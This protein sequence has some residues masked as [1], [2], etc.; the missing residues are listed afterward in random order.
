MSVPG[1]RPRLGSAY[2][3][4][5][6][7]RDDLHVALKQHMTSVRLG[8]DQINLDAEGRLHRAWFD[9]DSYQ[10]GLDGSLRRVQIT[11]PVPSKR[12]MEIE[13]LTAEERRRLFDRTLSVANEALR[14]IDENDA[15]AAERL[16]KIAAWSPDR[17]EAEIARFGRVYTPLDALPPDQQLAFVLQIPDSV[18]TFSKHMDAALEHVG[19]AL[20]MRQGIYLDAVGKRLGVTDYVPPAR[21]VR[22]RFPDAQ[23][24]P[25]AFSVD[26]FSKETPPDIGHT[27][28]GIGV[29]NISIDLL[30]GDDAIRSELGNDDPVTAIVETVKALDHEDV[31]RSVL[32]YLSAGGQ[33]RG[34]RHEEATVE[35]IARM[36]LGSRDRV[37]LSLMEWAPRGGKRTMTQ[38]D[39]DLAAVQAAEFEAQLRECGVAG[40]IADCNVFR[41][42][43]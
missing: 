32:V 17:Y 31:I 14:A 36:D 20:A 7:L 33:E 25:I 26:A 18:E 37:Y 21:L 1:D 2:K 30:S 13:V 4:I 27:L 39:Y 9:G 41:F 12:W 43:Y 16:R 5:V 19:G 3:R 6:E 28:N 35:A 22:E 8:S 34:K 42:V 15:E 40:P 10:R 38:A 11:R 29:R 23:L 24:W